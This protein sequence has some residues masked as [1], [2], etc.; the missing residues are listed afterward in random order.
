MRD[1][2]G[3]AV[4]RGTVRVFSSQLHV[5]GFVLALHGLHVMSCLVIGQTR[6]DRSGTRAIIP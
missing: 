4:V 6:L 5:I 2:C 3:C 1:L